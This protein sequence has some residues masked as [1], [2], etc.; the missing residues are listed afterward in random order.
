MQNAKEKENFGFFLVQTINYGWQISEGK[1]SEKQ[2]KTASNTNADQQQNQPTNCGFS[3]WTKWIPIYLFFEIAYLG[4]SIC[5][6]NELN[7]HTTM[8]S[9][10]LV[11]K[12]KFPCFDL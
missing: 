3:G 11:H 4:V 6:I 7:A 2:N 9:R 12:G 8:W 10:V 5:F 1:Y